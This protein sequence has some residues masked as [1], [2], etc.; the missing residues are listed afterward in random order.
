M[1][2]HLYTLLIIIVGWVLFRSDTI[3]DAIKYIGRMFGVI[4]SNHILYGINR[5]IRLDIVIILISACLLCGENNC[6][7]SLHK[8]NTC[9]SFLF[10][11]L[12]LVL[13][14]I[15]ICNVAASTYNPFIYFRF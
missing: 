12:L 9:A 3:V 14:I 13:F 15:S 4:P 11:G 5:Y 2:S 7:K 8:N 10:D 1:V 6:I